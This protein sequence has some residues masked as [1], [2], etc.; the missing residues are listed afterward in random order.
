LTKLELKIVVDGSSVKN[1]KLFRYGFYIWCEPSII[2][3]HFHS[4]QTHANTI[5]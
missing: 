1:N 2:R 4:R 3:K 5:V